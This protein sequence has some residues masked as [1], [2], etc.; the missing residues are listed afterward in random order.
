MVV[1]VIWN[2]ARFT[3]ALDFS[4]DLKPDDFK[5]TDAMF[6]AFR[7]FVAADPAF[8]VTSAMVDQIVLSLKLEMRFNIVTAAYGRVMGDRV[9]ITTDDLQVAKA[10]DVLPKARDFAMWQ[11][12]QDKPIHRLHSNLPI[13]VA[14]PAGLFQP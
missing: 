5:I 8:K 11:A 2:R 13:R 1:F 4:H 6:K 12:P 9:F 7:D 10:M 3:A 14:N